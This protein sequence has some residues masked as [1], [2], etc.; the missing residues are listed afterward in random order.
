MK[1]LFRATS[2]QSERELTVSLD[3]DGE[4]VFEI[5]DDDTKRTLV[6]VLL[7]EEDADELMAALRHREG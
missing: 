3:D 1:E 7:S 4:V 2:T 6:D 5:Q